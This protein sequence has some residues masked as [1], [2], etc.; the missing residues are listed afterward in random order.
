MAAEHRRD[1]SGS[2]CLRCG[3]QRGFPPWYQPCGGEPAAAIDQAP[4]RE[5]ARA[6]YVRRGDCA[7]RLRVVARDGR[8]CTCTCGGCGLTGRVWVQH[9]PT[10]RDAPGVRGPRWCR[11]PTV[12]AGRRKRGHAGYGLPASNIV[13]H[14]AFRVVSV[15]GNE[16]H[17][18]HGRFYVECA[19]GHRG[20]VSALR[21]PRARP[22]WCRC[23]EVSDA[24]E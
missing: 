17:V 6:P 19:G 16:A 21:A 22:S 5:R 13:V 24:A 12:V 7:G 20:Y 10:Y 11:C 3:A 18:C 1:A 14:N 4:V 23:E 8:R 2:R 9:L 15:N